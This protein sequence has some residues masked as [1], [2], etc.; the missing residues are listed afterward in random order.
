MRR[1]AVVTGTRAEYGLLRHLMHL[2]RATAAVN[3]GVV[4]AGMHLAPQFGKTVTEVEQDGFTIVGRVDMLFDNDDLPAMAKSVGIGIYGIAQALESFR[5]DLCVVLGDRVEAFAGAAAAS[6]QGI[7]VAHI[8]GGDAGTA[9]L[10]ESMRHA[11]TKL[12]HLHFTASELSRRRVLQMGER[13]EHVWNVGAVGLD[14]L[15][16]SDVVPRA[17]LCERLG[18]PRGEFVLAVL[19][20]VPTNPPE[21]AALVEETLNALETVGMPVLLVYPNADSG[22]RSMI[23]AIEGWAARPWLRVERHLPRDLYA[24]ALKHASVMVGN[25]SS[26]IIEAP[27]FGTPVVNVGTRQAGRERAAN[28]IDVPPDRQAI[29]DGINKALHDPVFREGLKHLENPYGDGRA[30][31]RI[32]R[33][34]TEIPLTRNLL[35]KEFQLRM[36]ES[37]GN[38]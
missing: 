11:I 2:L 25:S 13:S 16:H 17:L 36:F 23:A 22:G 20:P 12:A 21:T 37:G 32:A 7:P 1:I 38:L 28:V 15:L 18:L 8:H 27:A 26:G 9:G 30:S 4:V 29:R 3:L 19:H 35:E 33:V 31:E 14:L 34:L 24:S 10:D 6:L 5:A